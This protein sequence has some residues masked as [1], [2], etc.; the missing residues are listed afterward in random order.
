MPQS[1]RGTWK[2]KADFVLALISY[3]NLIIFTYSYLII[4]IN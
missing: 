3:G 1:E 4:D 2:N